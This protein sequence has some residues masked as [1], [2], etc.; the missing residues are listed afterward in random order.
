MQSH[1]NSRTSPFVVLISI[2]LF[3][4]IVCSRDNVFFGGSIAL[5]P[6]IKNQFDFSI[7]FWAYSENK[8]CGK[9]MLM[10]FKCFVQQY[11][12]HKKTSLINFDEVKA[13]LR[14]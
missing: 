3:F 6:K 12:L 9:Q 14:I 4:L 10:I 8:I 13:N 7:G 1:I 2:L 11:N 5:V